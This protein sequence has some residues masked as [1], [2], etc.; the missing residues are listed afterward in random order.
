MLCL[1]LQTK[2]IESGI[3]N[4][5]MQ[6]RRVVASGVAMAVAAALIVSTW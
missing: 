3:R 4:F 5:R 2:H 6:Y 1:A